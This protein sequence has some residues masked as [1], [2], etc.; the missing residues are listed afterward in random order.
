[1]KLTS[2]D[3]FRL[4]SSESGDGRKT[5]AFQSKNNVHWEFIGNKDI[6]NS[7]PPGVVTS[8]THTYMCE[9][10]HTCTVEV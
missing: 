3:S 6:S 8:S 2:F 9:H 4:T 5:S 1:M 7:I 10:V